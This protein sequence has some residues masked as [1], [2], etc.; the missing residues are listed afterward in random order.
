MSIRRSGGCATSPTS[1]EAAGIYLP[2]PP[3][4]LAPL[5]KAKPRSPGGGE[6]AARRGFLIFLFI[7]LIIIFL[8]FLLLFII[9]YYFL[10]L[11]IFLIILLFFIIFMGCFGVLRA[12]SPSAKAGRGGM[13]LRKLHPGGSQ[14]ENPQQEAA[15][16][17]VTTRAGVKATTEHPCP[18]SPHPPPG[19]LILAGLCSGERG[20]G[21]SSQG[22]WNGAGLS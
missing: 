2:L 12:L 15:G 13:G 6:F 1:E 22:S 14:G 9:F 7:F 16:R 21:G 8:L 19:T 10:F 18:L 3:Q 20:G 5:P 17:F 4:P 11:I